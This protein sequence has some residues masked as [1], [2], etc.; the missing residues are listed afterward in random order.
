[1]MFGIVN[2][3]EKL[4]FHILTEGCATSVAAYPPVDLYLI[5]EKSS[6]KNQVVKIKL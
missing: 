5:F 4:F 6:C 3:L 2:N 1:M